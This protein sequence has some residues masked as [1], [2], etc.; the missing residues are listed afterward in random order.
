MQHCQGTMENYGVKIRNCGVRIQHLD[1]KGEHYDS[2]FE[3]CGVTIQ[4]GEDRIPHKGITME[5]YVDDTMAHCDSTV[6]S[7]DVLMVYWA[8]IVQHCDGIMEPSHVVSFFSVY[9]SYFI[10]YANLLDTFAL[11]P[12]LLFPLIPFFPF[13]IPHFKIP[14]TK[15]EV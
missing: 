13:Y 7:C 9:F 10:S 8:L 11:L 14:P 6:K 4:H 3:H 2:V 5:Y 15:N 12:R 1:G